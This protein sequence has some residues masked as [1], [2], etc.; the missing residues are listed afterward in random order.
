[1]I[2]AIHPCF[3]FV[4]WSYLHYIFAY[5][6]VLST[7]HW[8]GCWC[9]GVS[10]GVCVCLW[11]FESTYPYI[12]YR[13]FS[14]HWHLWLAPVV[15]GSGRVAKPCTSFDAR[16]CICNWGGV[17]WVINV[18]VELGIVLYRACQKTQGTSI[19]PASVTCLLLGWINTMSEETH[20]NLKAE[21]QIHL[22]RLKDQDTA[23]E[24]LL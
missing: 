16:L 2:A 24:N 14:L 3:C 1:M 6:L 17:E 22:A 7:S 9:R 20:L 18:Q 13:Y 5:P 12:C 8:W 15:T 10:G 21:D 11:M 19:S 23:V 4:W